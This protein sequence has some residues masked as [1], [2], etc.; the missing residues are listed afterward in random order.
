MERTL[1]IL[2][3]RDNTLDE[4]RQAMP[5]DMRIESIDLRHRRQDTPL[6]VPKIGKG[7]DYAFRAPI[8]D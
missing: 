7:F 6:R 4:I 5:Q 8:C 1:L 3:G 2:R